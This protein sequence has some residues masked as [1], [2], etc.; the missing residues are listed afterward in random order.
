MKE[1]FDEMGE[2][3]SKGLSP[4]AIA[5]LTLGGIGVGWWLFGPSNPKFDDTEVPDGEVDQERIQAMASEMWELF[6]NPRVQLYDRPRCDALGRYSTFSNA[7][8]VATANYYKN[9][10]KKTIRQSLNDL[11]FRPCAPWNEPHEDHVLIRMQELNI[12]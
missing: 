5:G 1:E 10:F 2:K 9:K 12:P 7:E 8:F 6:D 3:K 11:Y 4:W